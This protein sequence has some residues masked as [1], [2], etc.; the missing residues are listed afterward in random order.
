MKTNVLT[1]L[2]RAGALGC[3]LSMPVRADEALV[4]PFFINS[5]VALAAT[6]PTTGVGQFHVIRDFLSAKRELS[7]RV[8][9]KNSATPVRD[10][11]IANEVQPGSGTW[12]CHPDGSIDIAAVQVNFDL[13]KEE[14][15][16]PNFIAS[17]QHSA[18]RSELTELNVS[19][20]DD[21]FVLAFPMSLSG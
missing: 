16:E 15:I 2:I 14:G 9:P 13:L 6:L 12:F 18:D 10:F 11:A 5:V 7:V 8:N 4:P 20:R 21:V 3:A 17:D 1:L 19:A